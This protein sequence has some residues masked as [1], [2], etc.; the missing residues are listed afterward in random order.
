MGKISKYSLQL[1]IM[2]LASV[3][4]VYISATYPS[5]GQIEYIEIFTEGG[6]ASGCLFLMFW[7][8]R[9]NTDC[10]RNIY[11]LLLL[12]TCFLFLGHLLDAIDEITVELAAIDLMEDIFTPIGFIVFIF[13]NFRWVKHHEE[14]AN[15][16]KKLAKT[17]PL[18]GL[19]NRRAFTEKGNAILRQSA[20][21]SEK[22]ISI[23]IMD[24]DYFKQVND[25]YGH[26]FG[27]QVL[28]EITCK[29]KSILRKHDYIAR[30]GGEEFIVLL[31]DT[32]ENETK[33]VAEKIRGCVE[34][35]YI[36]HK[37]EKVRC[38]ISLGAAI[39]H[40]QTSNLDKLIGQADTALYKAKANGRNCWE[41]ATDPI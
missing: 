3:L 26:Q 16:M 38:T 32:N 37:H 4:T 14:Q 12:S 23:I 35:L 30:L 15:I 17:D 5:H 40:A 39:E 9:L 20:D 28:I 6:I 27:D 25:R 2:L 31:H 24:I 10:F 8:E 33:L 18:T 41:L 29:I 22:K 7:I 1:S 36:S 19:L 21:D 13:A 11:R 34:S